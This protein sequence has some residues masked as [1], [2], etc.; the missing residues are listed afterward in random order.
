MGTARW[1]SLGSLL[2]LARLLEGRLVGEEEAGF[3]ECDKFFYA[4]TPPAGL[5]TDSHV[6]ICQRAEG[7][8]RF[9]TLYST[10]DRIPVYS[11]F[12]APR[13]APGG[14]EQRWLVEPQV[15]EVVPEPGTVPLDLPPGAL[16]GYRE[17]PG[18]EQQSLRLRCLGPR[19][20]GSRSTPLRP[21]S[22]ACLALCRGYNKSL[23]ICEPSLHFMSCRGGRSPVGGGSPYISEQTSA[24]FH[25]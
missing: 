19:N 15:S 8:E 23:A 9:A 11:A 18:R 22:L 6:K 10:R 17:G 16:C 20:S 14:A 13:P 5:A 24:V 2:A 12:R 7:A 25:S 3:G 4:G 21:R 1:F